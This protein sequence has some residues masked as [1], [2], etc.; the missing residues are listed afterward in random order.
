MLKYLVILLSD[1]AVSYCGYNTKED[2]EDNIIS[3]SDLHDAIKYGMKENLMI[4][5]V[6][7][8]ESLSNEH[9]KEIETIDHINIMPYHLAKKE[10]IGVINSWD[11]TFTISDC[12]TIIIRTSLSNIIDHTEAL[13][14]LIT[15]HRRVNIAIKNLDKAS[16]TEIVNYGNWI[17]SF[18]TNE[19]KEVVINSGSI[20]QLS[21]IADR[22]A[23]N[24]MNNCNAGDEVIT[25]APDGQFYICPGFYYEGHEPSG[26]LVKGL[27]IVNPELLKLNRAPICRNCDAWQCKRCVWSN[28]HRT[29]EVNTP[30]RAQCLISH[31]EREASRQLLN[32]LKSCGVVLPDVEIKELD[33]ND[34]FEKLTK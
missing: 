19:F 20:P 5:F 29:L 17:L 1:N 14:K 13:I 30:G 22:L 16:D 18:A 2:P 25:I 12:E 28:L 24:S 21:I 3:V 26:N 33:Y 23:L 4:Q 8:N 34:P 27:Q 9:I 7:P 6:Y 11:E 32:S 10:D 31:L 15:R